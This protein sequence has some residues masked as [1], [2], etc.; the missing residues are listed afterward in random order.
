[1]R[2]K[3]KKQNQNRIVRVD[4]YGGLKEVVIKEDIFDSKNNLVEVCFRGENSSGIVELS[5]DDVEKINAELEKSR[6]KISKNVKV[7]K[8][9]K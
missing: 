4:A 5:V 9:K 8:F 7:M 2:V 3:V 1:M 6:K